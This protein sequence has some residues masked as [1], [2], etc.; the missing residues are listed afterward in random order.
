MTYIDPRD[1]RRYATVALR[2]GNRWFAANLSFESEGSFP[3]DPSPD[4][5][6][7]ATN[8]GYDS[9]KYGR[10]FNWEAAQISVPPGWRVPSSHEWERLFQA[11]GGFA[12]NI[13]GPE[14]E[15]NDVPALVHDLDVEFGG[16]LRASASSTLYYTYFGGFMG[17]RFWSSS[18]PSILSGWEQ[19]K[20]SGIYYLIRPNPPEGPD[21]GSAPSAH[22]SLE[23]RDYAFSVRCIAC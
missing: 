8:P 13:H 5:K 22:K 9:K 11:Y 15:T 4:E 2:D 6:V 16:C 21:P 23:V 1:G 14:P 12:R 18:K 19:H 20:Y 17:A 10:L 7:L 3:P